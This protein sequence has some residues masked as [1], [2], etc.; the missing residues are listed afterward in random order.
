MLFFADK[1]TV[2]FFDRKTVTFLTQ[3]RGI[4]LET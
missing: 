1:K 2:S 3:K 4:L